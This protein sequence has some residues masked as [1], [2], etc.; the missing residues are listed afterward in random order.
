MA[1]LIQFFS[2][3]GNRTVFWVDCLMLLVWIVF[4][5]LLV[6]RSPKLGYFA[7]FVFV[8]GVGIHLWGFAEEWK[9]P[10]PSTFLR[11]VVASAK[12][13][14]SETS[15]DEIVLEN[16]ALIE[17]HECFIPIYIFVYLS[18]L[19]LSSYYLLSIFGKKLKSIEWLKV[20]GPSCHNEGGMEIHWYIM[21][22]IHNNTVNLASDLL[23]S[24]ENRVVFLE[25]PAVEMDMKLTLSGLRNFFSVKENEAERLAK[26]LDGLNRKHWMVLRLRRGFE[27]IAELYGEN[28]VSSKKF[29]REV[30][31]PGLDKFLSYDS[32][33]G[34]ILSKKKDY[35]VL[36]KVSLFIIGNDENQN[37][38]ICRSLATIHD[39][40]CPIYCK[41][42]FRNGDE[43]SVI[44]SY[45]LTIHYVDPVRLAFDQIKKYRDDNGRFSYH[46]IN[47][48]DKNPT[49]GCVTSVFTGLVLG[50]GSA[51]QAALD[52]LYSFGAFP[53]KNQNRSPFECRVY[54]EKMSDRE[55]EYRR[56]RCGM[57]YS[58][59]RFL[60][61][62]VGTAAFWKQMSAVDESSV[63]PSFI[64]KVNYVFVTLGDDNK[65][66]E[67]GLALCDFMHQNRL[68]ENFGNLII[69]IHAARINPEQDRL[70]K[71]YNHKYA[72]ASLAVFGQSSDIW[73]F[74]VLTDFALLKDAAV[75]YR[76][77]QIASG[78]DGGE[79]FMERHNRM[80]K[81][82]AGLRI[83]FDKWTYE[84]YLKLKRQE[85]QD[86]ENMLHQFTKLQ[87]CTPEYRAKYHLI[88]PKYP[89]NSGDKTHFKNRNG[90]WEMAHFIGKGAGNKKIHD[91]F[92]NLAI[93]EHIRWQAS[94]ETMGYAFGETT[95]DILKTHCCIRPYGDLNEIDRTRA[96][97]K[98]KCGEGNG[99]PNFGETKHYDWIVVKTALMQA[100]G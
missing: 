78:Q 65:N 98:N 89:E 14:L 62:G 99:L 8:S 22:G 42:S 77:Y 94:L 72:N 88:P 80:L 48:V 63:R 68:R 58:G 36:P 19:S 54:D 44:Q 71:L 30:G 16:R 51:G 73:K 52:F 35:L 41:T 9:A 6:Y 84:E 83:H 59:I 25:E 67:T 24:D 60:N 61:T 2:I 45:G 69:L 13:F 57:D 96:E 5:L 86:I 56:Q 100:Q 97:E 7:L 90:E 20:N 49:L 18:A 53:G 95:C 1:G 4:V 47:F 74:D 28:T 34:T 66:I 38:R 43:A 27:D 32:S 40:N 11:S 70:I 87:L 15:L 26:L 91:L 75:Y 23:K 33:G 3:S 55:G 39:L 50:F 21:Y 81:L 82:A 64:R 92:E 85:K 93:G 12:L 76:A 37:D 17:T 29:A 46:P 31:L 10:I 79:L